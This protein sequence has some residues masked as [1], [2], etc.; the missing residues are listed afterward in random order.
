MP[1]FACCLAGGAAVSLLLV[2][3]S[4]IGR[5]AGQDGAQADTR[6]RGE[7]T[8][9]A[10]GYYLGIGHAWR[11]GPSNLVGFD[12]GAGPDLSNYMIL[13]G[14]YFADRN[15]ISYSGRDPDGAGRIAEFVHVGVYRRHE[16]G[17]NRS[18]DIGIRGAAFFEVDESDLVGGV[19][20]GAYV[21]PMWGTKRIKWGPRISMGAFIE[22]KAEFGINVAFLNLRLTL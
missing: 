12:V 13:A 14:S 4:E 8:V 22:D 2:A 6:L 3:S 15:F 1:R 11:T 18:I 5:A 19:F 10:G 7:W 20:V 17:I 16:P 9:D 21:L